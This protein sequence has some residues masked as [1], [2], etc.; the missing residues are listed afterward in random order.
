MKQRIVIAVVVKDGAVISYATNEHDDCKRIGYPTG[1]GYEL[2]D[3][4]QYDNHAEKKASSGE[5]SGATMYLIGHTYACESCKEAV[6][7]SGIK[8]IKIL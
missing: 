7:K 1:E 8:E 4:C 5:V 6:K 3:G 2:C